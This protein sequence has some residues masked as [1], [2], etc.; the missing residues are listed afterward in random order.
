MFQSV[1]TA[2]RWTSAV[3][4]VALMLGGCAVSEDAADGL[5]ATLDATTDDS[6]EIAAVPE[7]DAWSADPMRHEGTLEPRSPHSNPIVPAR[8]IAPPVPLECV[9]YAREVSKVAIKGDAWVWWRAAKGRYRRDRTPGVGSV[10]VLK[11]SARLRRGHIAVVSRVLNRREI[12]VD[13]AN[14]LNRGQIHKNARVRDVSAGNDWSTVRIWYTPGN[15]LGKR[16]YPAH[17]FIHPERQ[18]TRR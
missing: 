13:H 15:T 6:Y 2:G 8:I 18:V 12:L 16:T 9:P 10:L 14:W 5:Q 17:G 7:F 4:A 3:F 11:R 1:T